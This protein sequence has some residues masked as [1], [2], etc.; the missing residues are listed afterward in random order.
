MKTKVLITLT[1]LASLTFTGCSTLLFVNESFPPE[2]ELKDNSNH[3]AIINYFDYTR[4]GFIKEKHEGV[5]HSAV[6]SFLEGTIGSFMDGEITTVLVDTMVPYSPGRS[7]TELLQ[8]E[9]ISDVCEEYE[10]T[11]LMTLDSVWIGFDWETITE[12]D[13]EGSRSKTKYFYLLHRSY[14]S[15]YDQNGELIDRSFI[16]LSENYKSRPTISGLVTIQPALAKAEDE[17]IVMARTA[18]AVYHDK[19]YPS[20]GSFPYTVYTGKTFKTAFESMRR[21]YWEDAVEELLPLASSRDPKVAS[22]AAHNIGVCYVALGDKP[23]A[24]LWF[25]EAGR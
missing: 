5:Y 13:D 1:L 19:F 23:T 14:L 10:A 7:F 20:S 11:H 15:L 2:I 16:D 4:P 24:E 12:E 21:G 9:F 6:K 22:K 3:F 8:P 25:A 17:A 18:A